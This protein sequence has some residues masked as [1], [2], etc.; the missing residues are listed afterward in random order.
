MILEYNI[1]E[2]YPVGYP[3]SLTTNSFEF[4]VNLNVNYDTTEA[5]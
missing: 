3:I 1:Y 5:N 4:N 2:I